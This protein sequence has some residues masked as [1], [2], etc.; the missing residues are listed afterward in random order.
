[1]KTKNPRKPRATGHH[2][3]Q[4]RRPIELLPEAAEG[5]DDLLTTREVAAWFG[6]SVQWAEIGRHRGYGPPFKEKSQGTI[7]YKRSTLLRWLSERE[8]TH[9]AKFREPPQAEA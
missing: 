2:I 6:T 5:P 3:D 9:T 4:P 8:H 1:M 7:R